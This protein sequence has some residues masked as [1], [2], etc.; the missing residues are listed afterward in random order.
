MLSVTRG[1]LHIRYL[2]T[3]AQRQNP[4]TRLADWCR[5]LVISVL[6]AAPLRAPDLRDL[7]SSGLLASTLSGCAHFL[8]VIADSHSSMQDRLIKLHSV[9]CGDSKVQFG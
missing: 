5:H 4:V 6:S 3:P 2:A 9:D 8:Q 1:S 7:N